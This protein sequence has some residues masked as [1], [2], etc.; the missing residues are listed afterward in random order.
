VTPVSKK[1]VGLVVG[2]SPGQ[3]KV[4][5]ATD[6]GVPVID[7]KRFLRLLAEGRDALS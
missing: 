4:Q 5:R 2:E 7:E 1:T 3:S 6:L